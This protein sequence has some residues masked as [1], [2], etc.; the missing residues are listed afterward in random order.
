MAI[1]I[2]EKREGVN[3][4][5]RVRKRSVMTVGTSSTMPGD[6]ACAVSHVHICV[7]GHGVVRVHI[8][9]S[10]FRRVWVGGCLHVCVYAYV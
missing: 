4:R 10:A 1:T 7:H 6:H 9:L 2:N 5:K 3:F 8:G